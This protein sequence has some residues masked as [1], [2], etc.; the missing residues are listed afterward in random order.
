MALD[1]MT[2]TVSI[3]QSQHQH[4]Q[5]IQQERSCLLSDVCCMLSAVC[6]LLSV[7]TKYLF[8]SYNVS[9]AIFRK[10]YAEGLKVEREQHN[11]AMQQEQTHH[12]QGIAQDQVRHSACLLS[13]VC[14]P[15]HT[16]TPH[17]LT[18]PLVGVL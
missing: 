13:A 8:C 3:V 5:A 10:F 16:H 1:K 17:P 6:S 12:K 2:S 9:D 18:S 7:Q 4:E 14:C 11:A 15:P